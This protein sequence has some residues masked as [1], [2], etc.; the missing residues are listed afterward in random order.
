VIFEFTSTAGRGPYRR[1]DCV[2]AYSLPQ[3]AA[4][5]DFLTPGLCRDLPLMNADIGN[6]AIKFFSLRPII[7][8]G[9]H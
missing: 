2:G 3:N 5:Q 9:W 8:V 7:E 6:G 1:N 4:A